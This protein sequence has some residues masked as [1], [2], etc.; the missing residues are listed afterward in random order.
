MIVRVVTLYISLLVCIV[1][2]TLS[3]DIESLPDT[4]FDELLLR[5]ES[6]KQ[7]TEM[8]LKE[9]EETNKTVQALVASLEKFE[10]RPIVF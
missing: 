6:L 2:E 10:G 7:K 3:P 9:I 1:A 5:L 8:R 4:Q